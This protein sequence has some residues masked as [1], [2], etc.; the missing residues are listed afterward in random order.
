MKSS[1]FL[2]TSVSN[3]IH[4]IIFPHVLFLSFSIMSIGTL[5]GDE[6]SISFLV[7]CFHIL[8]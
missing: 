5:G 6:Q 2:S 8:V 1:F 3:K 7:R 4:S